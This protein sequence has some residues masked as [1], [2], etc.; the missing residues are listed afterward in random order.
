MAARLTLKILFSKFQKSHE[1]FRS[2]SKIRF[3][4]EIGQF[5]AIEFFGKIDR[6][7]KT[8]R[9]FRNLPLFRVRK[10]YHTSDEYAVEP[11]HASPLTCPGL[12]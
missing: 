10:R 1:I 5:N 9:F 2:L 4:F 11:Q 6:V 8:E 7:F 3:F 12:L